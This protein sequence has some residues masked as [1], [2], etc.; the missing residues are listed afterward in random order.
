MTDAIHLIVFR[1]SNYVPAL[2]GVTFN[3]DW[4]AKPVLYFGSLASDGSCV[5]VSA[6]D[7]V[8]P[9]KWLININLKLYFK[10]WGFSTKLRKTL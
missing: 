5:L 1:L 9:C 4:N 8:T 7:Q 10:G 2:L 6:H 3:S